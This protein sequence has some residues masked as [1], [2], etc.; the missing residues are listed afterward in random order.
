MGEVI[1]AFRRPTHASASFNACSGSCD[2][3]HVR[4]DVV[5]SHYSEVSVLR[6]SLT[7]QRHSATDYQ[8]GSATSRG[9]CASPCR[10]ACTLLAAAG[11]PRAA[12]S[13]SSA[14]VP[15]VRMPPGRGDAAASVSAFA[16]TLRPVV[17][18]LV[19]IHNLTITIT[20][21]I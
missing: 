9:R 12:A 19:K 7:T 16:L 3:L 20:F 21:Q 14:P 18:H 5:S 8:P 11:W 6:R 17:C 10:S 15:L 13:L 1:C 2:A 4:T